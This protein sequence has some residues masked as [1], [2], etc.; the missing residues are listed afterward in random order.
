MNNNTYFS[1]CLNRLFVFIYISLSNYFYFI[2]IIFNQNLF[3]DMKPPT[4]CILRYIISYLCCKNKLQY[5]HITFVAS[6]TMIS[7][8]IFA[9]ENASTG[10][11]VA[12]ESLRHL[13][14][15]CSEKA[16]T[17]RLLLNTCLQQKKASLN[18]NC[19]LRFH[20]QKC[21]YF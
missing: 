1:V 7:W 18:E 17:V 2:V 10:G 15:R 13:K 5:F 9:S 14:N 12:P 19:A 3:Y 8:K 6:F 11:H 21:P 4:R 16:D 20:T